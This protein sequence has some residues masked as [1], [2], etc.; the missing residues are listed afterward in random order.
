MLIESIEI[1][2]NKR[3]IEKYMAKKT[4]LMSRVTQFNK[5]SNVIEL[6]YVEMKILD[7]EIISKVKNGIS[8]KNKKDKNNI[9]MM[10]NTY[11]GK[12]E[13]IESIPKTIK[14]YIVKSNINKSYINEEILI[15]SVKNQL[16][17]Y[18]TKTKNINEISKMEI[19]KI[20]IINTKSIYKPYWI[21]NFNGKTVLIEA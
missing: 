13:S 4:P 9:M 10:V 18:L 16:I 8:F 6:R 3:D 19:S 21:I 15:N 20:N 12:V 17:V 11:D 7:Y 5:F 2:K 1:K 14:K